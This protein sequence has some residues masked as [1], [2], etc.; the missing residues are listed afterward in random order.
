MRTDKTPGLRGLRP[1]LLSAATAL[2]LAVAG[3]QV[4]HIHYQHRLGTVRAGVAYQSG[5]MPPR[6]MARVAQQLGLR[7]VIDLRTCQPGQDSTQTSGILDIEAE[8]KALETVGVRHLYLPTGQVPSPETVARF[9]TWVRKP[10]NRPFL[11]HCYHGIGRT[12]VF[13][14]IYRMEFEGWSNLR[15]RAAARFFLPGSSFSD[16]S[17][18]GRFLL[19]YLP[20]SGSG[21]FA[22]HQ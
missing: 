1:I 10:E 16:R 17:E 18:K 15:A 20:G 22:D 2:V 12:E 19:N 7:T 13:V 8:A 5:T 21:P 11:I 6:E 9:L 4:F 14:A 3:W